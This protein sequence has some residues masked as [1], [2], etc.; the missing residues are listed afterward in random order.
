MLSINRAAVISLGL[1]LLLASPSFAGR[2]FHLQAHR[3]V[4]A[5]GQRHGALSSNVGTFRRPWTP[6][7]NH[8]PTLSSHGQG[9]AIEELTLSHQYLRI[10]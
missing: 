8:L 1:S 3:A 9:V 2:R 6:K 7:H 10:P 5:F 4:G